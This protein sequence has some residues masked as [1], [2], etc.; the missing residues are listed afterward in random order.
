VGLAAAAAGEALAA[1]VVSDGEGKGELD[2]PGD[3]LAPGVISDGDGDGDVEGF[4]DGDTD[5]DPVGVAVGPSAIAGVPRKDAVKAIA[6]SGDA[7]KR[8]ICKALR[9]RLPHLAQRP[10]TRLP[11][12]RASPR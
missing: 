6:R 9:K 5:G 8:S 12:E 2:R 1:G 7:R 3:A 11:S 4:A 10:D